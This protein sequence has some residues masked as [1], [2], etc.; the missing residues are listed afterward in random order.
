MFRIAVLCCALFNLANLRFSF[1]FCLAF[2]GCRKLAEVSEGFSFS[3]TFGFRFSL[4]FILV[5]ALAY[6]N[7]AC[8]RPD[9]DSVLRL[10]TPSTCLRFAEALIQLKFG[11]THEALAEYSPGLQHFLTRVSLVYLLGF[12]FLESGR[13]HE[14]T[15]IL[16]VR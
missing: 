8:T 1:C 5:S 10:A 12:R 4:N 11:V 7:L 14:I 3:S 6:L 16:Q 13:S 9:I 15:G 2:E